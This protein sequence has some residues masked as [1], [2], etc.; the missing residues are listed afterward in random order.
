M[1]IHSFKCNAWIFKYSNITRISFD[2]RPGEAHCR[3]PKK[4]D[5]WVLKLKTP[6]YKLFDKLSYLLS[7]ISVK[8]L[9]TMTM[10]MMMMLLIMMMT[11][12]LI[13]MM[14]MTTKSVNLCYLQYVQQQQQQQQRAHLYSAISIIIR[15]GTFYSQ[16]TMVRT[17]RHGWGQESNPRDSSR[18]RAQWQERLSLDRQTRTETMMLIKMTW[19][20][21]TSAIYR[22]RAAKKS[23]SYLF[24]GKC[25]K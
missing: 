12:L 13:V 11:T 16:E 10:T 15:R 7:Q 3:D 6:W 22:R 23:N 21:V 4:Y 18:R 1:N 14:M 25:F 9:M 19:M 20:S 24:Y 8:Q 2:W 5:F 17:I